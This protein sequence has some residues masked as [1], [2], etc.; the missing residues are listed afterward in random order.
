MWYNAHYQVYNASDLD[1]VKYKTFNEKA[2]MVTA[3]SSTPYVIAWLD[4]ARTGPVVI[5]YPKGPSAGT[6]MSFFQLSIADLSFTGP[7]KG[8]GGKYNTLRK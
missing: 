3:N 5:D 6:I 4:L 1:F 7:D 2:G 8:K